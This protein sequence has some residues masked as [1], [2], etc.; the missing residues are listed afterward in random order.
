M[1]CTNANY[2]LIAGPILSVKPSDHPPRVLLLVSEL[3]VAM[4]GQKDERDEMGSASF[5]NASRAQ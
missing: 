3:I 2:L 5:A 4:Y 1:H